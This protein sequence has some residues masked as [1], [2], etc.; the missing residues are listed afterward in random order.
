M[1]FQD[2]QK[3]QIAREIAF[4]LK[5][6][7]FFYKAFKVQRHLGPQWFM[8]DVL[9]AH[10]TITLG[11][12]LDEFPA[13]AKKRKHAYNELSVY[14]DD[15]RELSLVDVRKGR[16]SSK[17]PGSTL[18][19]GKLMFPVSVEIIKT[20]RFNVAVGRYVHMRR[21][22]RPAYTARDVVDLCTRSIQNEDLKDQLGRIGDQIENAENE[23][24]QRAA[25]EQ[26]FSIAPSNH[27]GGVT[28][29]EMKRVYSGTFA[30]S[31]RT[32]PIYDKI[33]KLSANDICP[34]CGQRT[35]GT[36]DHY[37]PQSLHA[38]LVVT[39]ANLLPCCGDCNKAKLDAQPTTVAEQTLHPYFDDVDDDIWLYASVEQ[40][41]PA[42]LLFFPDPPNAWPEDK[43]ARV[44]LHFRTFGLGALYASHSAVELNNIRYGLQRIAERGTPDN[45]RAEL[46]RRAE[47]SK[48]AQINSWQTAM[49]YAVAASDW[50]CS[51]GYN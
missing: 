42:S 41:T 27:V 28:G 47:S 25:N 29:D 10:P 48:V 26:L 36:I 14:V 11:A 4:W 17:R 24:I 50:F 20:K 21:L 35:V 23:Y 3:R 9:V 43:Q 6:S 31:K 39:P 34:M 40:R 51:G 32:R 37:L 8:I 44:R 45:I 30:R 2:Q 33:K 5:L 19:L 15:L 38:T 1:S 16:A 18:T 13:E 7:N 12:L 46:L 22:H 49:Y